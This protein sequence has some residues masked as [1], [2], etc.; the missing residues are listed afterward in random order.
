MVVSDKMMSAEP[1]SE[2]DRLGVLGPQHRFVSHYASTAAQSDIS[3]QILGI[4]IQQKVAR[5]TTREGFSKDNRT[6]CKDMMSESG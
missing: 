6:G 3:P 2:V 4:E 5:S 1:R